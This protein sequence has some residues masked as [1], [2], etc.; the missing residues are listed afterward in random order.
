M[1]AVEIH[2]EDPLRIGREIAQGVATPRCDRHQPG[3]RCDLQSRHIDPG[4]LPDL[5][6][7]EI[8]EGKREHALENAVDRP[9]PIAMHRFAEEHCAFANR[10]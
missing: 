7:D 5:R 3:G 6:I 9:R 10:G 1:R 4:V 8:P 2:G